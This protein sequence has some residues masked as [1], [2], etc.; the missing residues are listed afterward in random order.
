M[1]FERWSCMGT[2][3]ENI[4]SGQ[5]PKLPGCAPNYTLCTRKGRVPFGTVV[6]LWK[7]KQNSAYRGLETIHVTGL[8]N[9][10][11]HTLL[12]SIYSKGATMELFYTTAQNTPL[13][14]KCSQSPAFLCYCFLSFVHQIT[15]LCIY[16]MPVNFTR[17]PCFV[18]HV[19]MAWD[20][21][22][23]S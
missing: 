16:V 2:G 5:K 15:V 9:C 11:L 6:C 7:G 22:Q 3:L 17:S 23:R 18:L 10:W 8:D 14:L 1:H 4:L 13:I 21:L 12:C 19:A 20:T